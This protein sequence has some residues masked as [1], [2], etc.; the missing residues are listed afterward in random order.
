MQSGKTGD[1][2]K[3]RSTSRFCIPADESK[4]HSFVALVISRLGDFRLTKGERGIALPYLRRLTKYSRQ[5]LARM[6]AKHRDTQSFAPLSRA[7]HFSLANQYGPAGVALLAE[8]AGLHD[9]PEHR[10]QPLVFAK[11][12]GNQAAM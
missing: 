9:A 4:Q 5:H 11:H 1:S 3:A 7:S 12:Q 2:F 10:Q 8:T 6:I